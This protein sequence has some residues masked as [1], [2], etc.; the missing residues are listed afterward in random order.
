MSNVFL[1][2]ASLEDNDHC[3]KVVQE[4]YQYNAHGEYT[5]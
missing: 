5:F 4:A 1:I 3:T 2:H